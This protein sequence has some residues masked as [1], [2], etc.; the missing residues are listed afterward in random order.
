[1][2]QDPINFLITVIGQMYVF[3]VVLRFLLQV[4]HADYYNPISQA[5]AKL[6][7][8]PVWPLSRVLPKIGRIDISALV[9]ALLVKLVIILLL[10]LYNGGGIPHPLGILIYA[11]VGVLDTVLTIYFWAILGAVII[12]W[13]APDSYH[14]GPQLIQ[15]LTE[16]VFAVA[17]KVIPPIGGL[18]LSPILIIIVIQ[19]IQS[20]L[21]RLL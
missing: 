16:P 10:V 15:Q 17:R 12:S 2:Q 6:T 1:M 7:N 11:L 5:I 13:V 18:D 19:L 20:Q 3:I 21:G 4:S 14:P 9:L 8:K